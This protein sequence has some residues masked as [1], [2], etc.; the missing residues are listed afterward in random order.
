M[1]TY[2]PTNIRTGEA[3]G[4][5]SADSEPEALDAYVRTQRCASYHEWCTTMLTHPG[6]VRAERIEQAETQAKSAG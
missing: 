2:W 6:T 1:T 5:F 4:V 3:L